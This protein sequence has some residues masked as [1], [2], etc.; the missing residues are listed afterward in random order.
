MTSEPRRGRPRASSR[1]ALEEITFS[2]LLRDGYEA[3]TVQS[4]IAA[5]GV[6]R[7]TFFRYFG[8]KGAV[9]WG[10][11]DRAIKRLGDRLVASGDVQAMTAVIDAVAESTRLSRDAA[12]DTWLDRF[13]VLDQ[14]PALVG[15]T[16]KHWSRWA[17]VIAGDIERRCGVPADSVVSAAI[18]GAVQ[19]AYVA[20][21]RRWASHPE[22]ADPSSVRVEL[23]P[24]GDAL[25]AYL[26]AGR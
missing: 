15:E 26:D 4:I 1:E 13:R 16:A 20:L 19:S 22:Q 7:T 23:R 24:L 2:L 18:G 21:L 8:S 11:F 3:T 25:Q 9:I 17:G 5:G 14:D 6:S 10:E 12:P